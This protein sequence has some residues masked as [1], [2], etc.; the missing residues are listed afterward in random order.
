[1]VDIITKII[2]VQKVATISPADLGIVMAGG[3]GGFLIN[4]VARGIV[5]IPPGMADVIGILLSSAGALYLKRP[6]NALS[7][8]AATGITIGALRQPLNTTARMFVARA[9][10]IANENGKA[11][12]MIPDTHMGMTTFNERAPNS[13]FVGMIQPDVVYMSGA[14][15]YSQGMAN[16]GLSNSSSV[17]API[18][19]G[20]RYTV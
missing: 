4:S 7:A 14:A 2:G 9:N 11:R 13:P 18:G 10:G 15:G 17:K 12:K 16:S 20:S 3:L 8:G 19:N 5:Q 1:M 6:W